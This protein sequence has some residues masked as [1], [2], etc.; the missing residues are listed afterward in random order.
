MISIKDFLR[1]ITINMFA[2][3]GGNA[4]KIA[5]YHDKHIDMFRLG[6]TLQNLPII[7]LHKYTDAKLYPFREGDED[8]LQKI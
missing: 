3:F 8:I 6:C 4:K 1:G 2:N 7:C 5:F